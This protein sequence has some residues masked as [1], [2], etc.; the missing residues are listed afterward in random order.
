MCTS[1]TGCPGTIE[2]HP[3]KLCVF[4]SV[5][6]CGGPC[7]GRGT[8]WLTLSLPSSLRLVSSSLLVPL[9]EHTLPELLNSPVC[10][11][12]PQPSVSFPVHKG[13]TLMSLCPEPLPTQQLGAEPLTNGE[14]LQA[15]ALSCRQGSLPKALTSLRASSNHVP[16]G[17]SAQE[18]Q[19]LWF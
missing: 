6:A 1:W 18:N 15:Y 5:C 16:E 12:S 2:F 19:D 8:L 10:C 9:R 17:A 13:G 3:Q 7:G 4:V 11:S 14:C